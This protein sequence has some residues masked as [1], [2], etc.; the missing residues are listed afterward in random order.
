MLVCLYTQ[1]AQ[2]AE[3]GDC[4]PTIGG[5]QSREIGPRTRWSPPDF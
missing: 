4:K 2:L 1:L 3:N 5:N